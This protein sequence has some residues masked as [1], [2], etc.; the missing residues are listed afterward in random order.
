MT[1]GRIWLEDAEGC[2]V[3]QYQAKEQAYGWRSQRGAVGGGLGRAP[4]SG[5]VED[6]A[7]KWER[8][9]SLVY[10]LDSLR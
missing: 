8:L 3:E 7:Q 2:M 4:S 1:Y 9:I 10:Y 5:K 6:L